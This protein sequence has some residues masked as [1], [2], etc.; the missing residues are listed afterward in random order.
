M[1]IVKSCLTWA[2]FAAVAFTAP[3][4]MQVAAQTWLPAPA[5]V[6]CASVGIPALPSFFSITPNP[7]E[8]GTVP[9]V[10]VLGGSQGILREY[11]IEI[12]GTE[13][14]VHLQ[15]ETAGFVP[16]QDL[17]YVLS[18]VPA[19]QTVGTYDFVYFE[20]GRITSPPFVRGSFPN[21]IS[22]VPAAV[23]TPSSG[24]TATFALVLLLAAFGLKRIRIIVGVALFQLLTTT[25]RVSCPLQTLEP[26]PHYMQPFRTQLTYRNETISLNAKG[27]SMNAFKHRLRRAKLLVFSFACIA[28]SSAQAQ[29]PPTVFTVTPEVICPAGIPTFGSHKSFS[30]ASPTDQTP[31]TMTL[32]LLDDTLIDYAVVRSGLIST[33]YLRIPGRLDTP[34]PA[35]PHCY[36]LQLGTLVNGQNEIVFQSAVRSS[37]LFSP[38]AETSAISRAALNVGLVSG[39]PVVGSALSALLCLL[40]AFV[41]M[42]VG[43]RNGFLATLVLALTSALQVSSYALAQG[44]KGVAPIATEDDLR[45]DREAIVQLN[46]T[47][48]KQNEEWFAEYK[49][50]DWLHMR[51][52]ILWLW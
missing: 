9:R 26:C 32:R 12:V 38:F 2:R 20:Y 22:A 48:Q 5:P 24:V 21:A 4:C 18:G 33:V 8:I 45:I 14:R 28:G 7:V 16:R 23:P 51:K 1:R 6:N 17:C 46:S 43:K 31:V 29:T 19:I 27:H 11:Y 39:I 13:F 30:P 15:T 47:S 40:L 52:S 3:V 36:E 50:T 34:P 10:A 44:A 35:V 41:G 49:N 25:L 42:R 37:G